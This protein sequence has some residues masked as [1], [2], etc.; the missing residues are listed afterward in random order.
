MSAAF[1]PELC[2]T[3]EL[4][5]PFSADP[6]PITSI[7][8]PGDRSVVRVVI[9]SHQPIVRHGLRGLLAAEPELEIVGESSDGSD[10]VRLARRLR[11]GAS[12]HSTRSRSP[13]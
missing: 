5:R 10:A 6:V 4:P 7:R 12:R 1:A 13:G 11:P 3:S 2:P 8:P 9:A